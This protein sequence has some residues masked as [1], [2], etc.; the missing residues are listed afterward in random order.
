MKQKNFWLRMVPVLILV[1]ATIAMS[2]GIYFKMIA[3]EEEVC[4]Q[5]LEVA[6][7]STAGKIKTRMTDNMNFLS[8][9][10]AA[11]TLTHNI[12][13]I[14]VVG[15]YID[16]VK[17]RTIFDRIDVIL[18]DESLITEEG[19]QVERGGIS[20]YEELLA[21]GPHITQ[22][23]TSSFSGE[24]I[25]CYVTPIVN[26][27]EVLGLLVGTI[28]CSTLSDIF[29]VFTYGQECQLFV[30][31]CA[32][33]NYIMDNWHGELGNIYELG[34]RESIYT[35]ETIDFIPMIINGE[36]ARH[37]YY[38]QM[39]GEKSYQYCA[40]VEGFGWEVCVVVQEDV[41]FANVKELEQELYKAGLIGLLVVFVYVLWNVCMNIMTLRSEEKIKQLEYEKAK[42]EA[43]AA[44]LSNMSHDIKTPLNGIVGMLQVIQNHRGEADLVDDCLQKIE[45]SAAYLSTLTSDILDINEIENDKL[46]LSEEAIDMNQLLDELGVLMERQA[47]DAEVAYILDTSGLQ[48]PYILGSSVHI[49]RILINLIGNAIKYSKNAGKC[50][51]V[52]VTD[53]ELDQTAEKRMYRFVIKDNGIGMSEEFQKTM[54]H[55]FEQETIDARSEYQGYGLGLTIVNHL[56]KKMEGE[57]ALDSAKGVGS[58][59]TVTI[60]FRIGTESRK[61]EPAEKSFDISGLLLLL[62]EDNAFNM[63]IAHVLLT[64]AGATV[65]MAENGKLAVER[66]AA[67][68][69]DT[70]D[71]IIMDVM[72]PVMDGWEAAREIRKMDRA[73]AGSVP[74]IAMTANTFAEDIARCMDAGM[75]AHVPKPLDIAQLMATIAEHC[76]SAEK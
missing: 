7:N 27:D 67:S 50:V 64:D 40:P 41:V 49:K 39:N 24:E 54:Y 47:K 48:Q 23:R 16:S 29:E 12:T 34:P 44:F 43:R 2:I 45:I 74:I 73:D 33:G 6:T 69:P 35:G 46:V 3:T 60:P 71:A 56:I 20:S 4:W 57:I 51:W 37:A 58:A 36:Q 42:N 65:D 32:D 15:R 76:T 18:P 14:E 8:A 62:V 17:E 9:A 59:F 53:E 30:I 72:M 19:K 75:N 25:I 68:A 1:T 22:R 5:R 10:A 70:Y 55:A 38:S 31:D 26:Q 21:K 52:T 13:D 28:N 63:E 11:Y 66:F 61:E